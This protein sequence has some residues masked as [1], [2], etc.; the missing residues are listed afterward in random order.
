[1]IN[2]ND[3]QLPSLPCA[4]LAC[5][6]IDLG[7]GLGGYAVQSEGALNI[8]G[9]GFLSLMG[10]ATVANVGVDLKCLN[11]RTVRDQLA[12]LDPSNPDVVVLNGSGT[13]ASL[14]TCADPKIF[15]IDTSSS[16][17]KFSGSAELCGVVVVASNTMIEATGNVVIN[18]LVLAMGPASNLG[19]IAASGTPRLFGKVV[20][21][22]NTIDT[23]LEFQVKGTADVNY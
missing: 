8:S 13:T 9:G 16:T 18:G 10:V 14:N 5:A 20:I 17:F 7:L 23:G 2:G 22:S 15:I 6:G 11:W 19:F 4:G 3:F 1:M 21:E 12:S